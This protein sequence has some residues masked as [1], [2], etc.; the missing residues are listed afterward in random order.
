MGGRAHLAFV[1]IALKSLVAVA[2][3]RP[4]AKNVGGHTRKV[5]GAALQVDAP[6]NFASLAV[7][8]SAYRWIPRG[9]QTRGCF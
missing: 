5:E 1:E 4:V 7:S 8:T 2:V 6:L 9:M 3:A